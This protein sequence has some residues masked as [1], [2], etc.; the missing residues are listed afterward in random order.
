M[1][2]F[3]TVPSVSYAS[4]R[5]Q[6]GASLPSRQRCSSLQKQELSTPTVGRMAKWSFARSQAWYRR[7]GFTEDPNTGLPVTPRDSDF[8]DSESS[9]DDGET[10]RIAV[11]KSSR[12]KMKKPKQHCPDLES[13]EPTDYETNDEG[14]K[15]VNVK[16]ED[17][18]E[19]STKYDN[20]K[21][22]YAEDEKA[23]VKEVENEDDDIEGGDADTEDAAEEEE[24][25]KND[26]EATVA[27]RRK[28]IKKPV[29]HWFDSCT[30]E[31]AVG[32]RGRA[33]CQNICNR[34]K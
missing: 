30:R 22:K 25:D 4:V 34:S 3:I 1:L 14:S 32:R 17:T 15:E 20:G 2:A 9:D 13:D 12:L 5:S 33:R 7:M 29:Q 19:I 27:V 6:F 23:D 26:E 21:D 11:R 10:A 24:D 28:S 31:G 18:T 16:N 8:S